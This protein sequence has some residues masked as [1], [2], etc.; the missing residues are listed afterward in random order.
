[1][2]LYLVVIIL[3][4]INIGYAQTQATTKDGKK[5][6]VKPDGTWEYAKSEETKPPPESTQPAPQ[7]PANNEGKSKERLER[8]RKVAEV[9]AR[10]E[11]AQVLKDEKK[12]K[13]L[14]EKYKK[15]TE[16]NRIN[17]NNIDFEVV[18]TF[19]KDYLDRPLRA[20]FVHLGEMRQYTESGTTVY[21]LE[22]AHKGRTMYAFPKA[23]ALSLFIDEDLAKEYF[24]HVREN[25]QTYGVNGR[26]PAHI[27]L[28]IAEGALPNGIAFFLGR[29]TCM[30]FVT[31]IGA[32]I[33]KLGN[34][35]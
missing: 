2:K 12:N 19:P 16:K 26:L 11:A 17:A 28:Q 7:E 15:E 6:V 4:C 10:G 24:V 18:A 29:I 14:I 21:F 23:S 1:M 22:I 3:L 31:I 33:K 20:K 32:R 25:I 13:K 35:Q 34:C 8:E 5:I 30:E 9:L 27:Q